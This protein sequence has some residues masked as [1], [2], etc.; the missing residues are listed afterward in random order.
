MALGTFAPLAL[1]V[2]DAEEN[3]FVAKKILEAMGYECLEALNG[4]EALELLRTSREIGLMIL[5][6]TMPVMDGYSVLAQIDTCRW[7]PPT[8]VVSAYVRKE[9]AAALQRASRVLD[10][11][12]NVAQF[13][14]I[15][16]QLRKPAQ[17]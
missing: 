4:L 13:M 3:R 12:L 14:Q 2:D 16:E 15:V 5:D 1:V 9:K 11:P 6:L 8:I 17:A 7:Q 10:K